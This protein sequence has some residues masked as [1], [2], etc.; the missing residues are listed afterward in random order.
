MNEF[1]SFSFFIE[2]LSLEQC[3]E[4]QDSGKS[5]NVITCCYMLSLC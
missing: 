4:N 2:I 5:S 1:T 3:C